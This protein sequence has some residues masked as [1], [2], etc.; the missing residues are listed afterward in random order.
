MKTTNA[1]GKAFQTPAPLSSAKTQKPSPRMRRPKVKI[2]Q[3]EPQSA[4]EDDV[5]EVEYMPPKEIPLPDGMDG[6]LPADMRFP[7]FEGANMTRG[8]W[9]TY[10]NPI[11]DDGRTRMQREFD[12]GLERDRKKRDDEFDRVF[13]EQQAQD[14]AEMRRYFGI[15]ETKKEAPKVNINPTAPKR[16]A[17]ALSTMRARSAVA[18]LSSSS[19]PSYAAPTAATKSRLPSSNVMSKK[20]AKP[21][22]R[23][24]S[25][26]AAAV[27]ASKSTIGYAQGR[28]A[29]A[30]PAVRKPLSNVTKPAPFSATIRRPATASSMHNRS[31]SAAA[32]IGRSH[33][34]A[35]RS[36]SASS[37][38]TLVA[39]LMREEEHFRTAEDV[40]REMRM[41]FLQDEED[42]DVD[43]WMNNFSSQLQGDSIGEDLEDFQLQLPEG[44]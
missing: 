2:H 36:V 25:R 7:M 37:D 4:S 5:P 10:H 43:A 9:E 42:E 39:P 38:A 27:A 17:S 11:E 32:T 40:E 14:D 41:L 31:A 24:A 33:V 16:T 6:Y 26:Q 13:E 19:K 8:I 18:A 21:L 35:S 1:K 3:P 28:A 12:E 22:E 23:S 30:G 29:R 44:F 20:S 15:E 34:P